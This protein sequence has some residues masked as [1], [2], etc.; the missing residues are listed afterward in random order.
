MNRLKLP[1]TT[2]IMMIRLRELSLFF[3][4][5][6]FSAFT[7]QA[8]DI[9]IEL[10]PDN[11]AL[12]QAFTITINVQGETLKSYDKFP[13]I[14]GLVKRG[15][16][17]SSS[18][19]IFNG[20]VSRSQSITQT[21]V[22]EKEGVVNIAPFNITVNGKQVSSPGKQVKVGPAQQR[23]QQRRYDPFGSDPFEDFFGRRDEPTEFIDLKDDAFLALTTDKDEVYVGEGVN[24]TLAFYI[25]EKNRAPLQFHDLTNQLTDIL[26]EIRPKNVWE[27]N[28]NIENISP[29]SVNINGERFTVYKVF[30]ASFFPLDADDIEF[31][32]VG[33]KMIKYQVAK[34]SSFFGQSRKE[35]FKTFYTK[36]KKIKVKQLP[37]HPLKD[38]VAVGNYSL[39]ENLNNPNVKTGES[40]QYQF[41]IKGVGNIAYINEPNIKTDSDLEI[42]PPNSQERIVRSG[43]TVKGTKT[44]SYY[45]SPKEPGA[46]NLG[47]YFNFVFFNTQ[48]N[49]YDTLKSDYKINVVGESLKNQALGSS[50]SQGLFYERFEGESNE[51][52]SLSKNQWLQPLVNI[53]IVLALGLTLFILIKKS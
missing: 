37:P 10:G 40:F 34:R 5:F 42:Y 35:G 16:S 53:I 3:L 39:E 47:D 9:S 24:A 49:R 29:E 13:D 43:T 41:Q 2:E 14:P 51:L 6:F 1:L 38:Q 50:M 48:K 20:Q 27:E 31:P 26:K 25:S 32:S 8:Q 30:Q 52:V 46:Y 21:Y 33:L 15:T 28:F 19:N 7:L 4:I 18:T 12:N 23:Q 22:A 36:A 11:I 17:S 44:F 45:V